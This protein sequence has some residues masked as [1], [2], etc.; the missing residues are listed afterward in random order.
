MQPRVVLA[1]ARLAAGHVGR[2]ERGVAAPQV[3]RVLSVNPAAAA[4]LGDGVAIEQ[5]GVFVELHDAHGSNVA[6]SDELSKWFD[7]DP[8]RFTEF[9][10]RYR[11]ELADH[12]D[13]LEELRGRAASGPLTRPRAKYKNPA[14]EKTSDTDPREAAKSCCNDPIKAL[15]V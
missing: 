9:R 13:R 10:T 2:A 6:P 3:P 4:C 15:N 1:P 7:H 12:S 8:A 11:D 5:S 14:T